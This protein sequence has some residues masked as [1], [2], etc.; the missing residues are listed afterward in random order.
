[1]T[2]TLYTTVQAEQELWCDFD[3]ELTNVSAEP[4]LRRLRDESDADFYQISIALM[5]VLKSR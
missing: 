2:F 4:H 3:S 1:M 5:Q